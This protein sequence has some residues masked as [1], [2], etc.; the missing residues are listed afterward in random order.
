MTA[1]DEVGAGV[2]PFGTEFT[3]ST[4]WIVAISLCYFLVVNQERVQCVTWAADHEGTIASGISP[5]RYAGLVKFAFS[6]E[7]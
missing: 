7:G 6:K 2:A 5:V 3:A 4:D 1:C